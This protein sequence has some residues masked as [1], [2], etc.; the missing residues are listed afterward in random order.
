MN[1]QEQGKKNKKKG[2]YFERKVR[3]DME[4]RGWIVDK[5]SNN[6]EFHKENSIEVSGRF[7]GPFGK[8]IPAKRKWNGRSLLAI[9][10]GFPD[11]ICFQ[12][13]TPLHITYSYEVIGVEVKYNGYL[14]PVEKEKCKWLLDN[15]VF[16]KIH[17]AST[18]EKRGEIKYVEFEK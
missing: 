10:T 4:N 13:F 18:G 15:D 16:S 14:K 1:K 9:G 7:G 3:K 8:L 11:F 5:W 2:A 17:I 6:V 12:K